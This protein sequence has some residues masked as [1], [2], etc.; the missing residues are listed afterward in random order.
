MAEDGTPEYKCNRCNKHGAAGTTVI[1][2]CT[3]IEIGND[4]APAVS[5][6]RLHARADMCELHKRAAVQRTWI[7]IN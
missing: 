3:V 2:R 7:R 4:E 6:A 1:M 5:A